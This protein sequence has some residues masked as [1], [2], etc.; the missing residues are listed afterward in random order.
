MK[1]KVFHIRL[2]KANQQNDEAVINQFMENVEVVNTTGQIVNT[3]S[4]SYW[5][6]LMFYNEMTKPAKIAEKVSFAI[7]EPLSED[8]QQLLSKLKNWRFQKSTE[9]DLPIYM[10]CNNVEL[11]S[12][13]KVKPKSIEQLLTI[14]GF[15]DHKAE[16]FGK[17]II[18]LIQ[19]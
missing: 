11:L 3:A 16:K 19:Q 8:E 9:L 6:I 5:S 10:I 14:K 1:S 4:V 17:E 7:D 2:D 12:V 15:D 13:V 18:G